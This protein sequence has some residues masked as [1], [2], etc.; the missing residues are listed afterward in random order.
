VNELAGAATGSVRHATEQSAA[1]DRRAEEHEAK[2]VHQELPE[3]AGWPPLPRR[4]RP[5][6][7]SLLL[8]IRAP[9]PTGWRWTLAVPFLAWAALSASRAGSATFL[10]S[11]P[12]V[13]PAGLQ[14]ASSGDLSAGLWATLQ[15]V[16]HGFGPA[17]LMSVPL[18]I[19][20]GSCPARQT[21]FEPLI[22]LLRYQRASAVVPPPVIW[23]GLRR[24]S[25]IAKDLVREQHRRRVT[26]MAGERWP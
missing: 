25:K 20:M 7:E 24:P 3:R 14:M 9:I 23:L 11:P 6:P 4:P 21:A 12:A 22:A 17:V 16:P 8:S 18:G 13:L 5:R 15:R 10:P 19:V 1:E 26:T 2:A